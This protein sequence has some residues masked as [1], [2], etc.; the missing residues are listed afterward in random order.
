MSN[1]PLPIGVNKPL[2]S[3]A[4]A[5]VIL[6][7]LT[8]IPMLDKH[9]IDDAYITFRYAD[10]LVNHGQLVFN[11]GERIEG[12]TN[13]FWAVL[14]SIF[15]F[16]GAPIAWSA[17]ALSILFY[18]GCGIRC[19]QLLKTTIPV[20]TASGVTLLL[21][22]M[23]GS[24]ADITYTGLETSLYAF[25][26]FDAFWALANRLY[27]RVGLACGL[28]FATRPEGVLVGALF[29]VAASELQKDHIKDAAKAGIIFMIFVLTVSAFRFFYYGSVIPNSI[30]A[31]SIPLT[32][33]VFTWKLT[34]VPYFLG[35][36][37]Y[38]FALFAALLIF[39]VCFLYQATRLTSYIT[40]AKENLDDDPERRM[41]I[42][43]ILA[44]VVIMMSFAVAIGNGGDWM[45]HWRLLIQY[46]ACYVLLARHITRLHKRFI[47]LFIAC[48][49]GGAVL[50][51]AAVQKQTCCSFAPEVVP[52]DFYEAAAVALK[53]VATRDD[54][55]SAEAA[56]YLPF[57]LIDVPF[58]DPLGLMDKHLARHG[59]PG[60]T[61]GKSD[62]NYTLGAVRP[63]FAVW[64]YSGHLLDVDPK[65]LAEYDYYC[66][67]QC[68]DVMHALLVMVR[69]D[70]MT[71]PT[72]AAF[73]GWQRAGD[74]AV[75]KRIEPHQYN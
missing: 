11:I 41:L 33:I 49:L 26:I 18:V 60:A 73:S 63:S 54:V 38:N 46:A 34:T 39:S 61:F 62:F 68:D 59:V 47:P 8:A 56:G 32:L 7:F 71:V 15:H 29:V 12:E 4:H 28:A 64:H 51:V 21:L 19:L 43:E 67:R 48:A 57:R 23:G 5:I 45:P 20:W 42:S 69:K 44:F 9:L 53:I 66:F 31:K 25:L 16:L 36:I 13:L 3:I 17:I 1:R 22:P 27:G 72:A 10:N 70:R 24:L 35:F 37:K 65:W 58:H 52:S 74:I 30:V 75:L 50:R 2:D 40:T 14:L 6:S 55:I